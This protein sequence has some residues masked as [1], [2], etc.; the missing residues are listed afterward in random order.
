MLRSLKAIDSYFSIFV[1][2]VDCALEN[3][4]TFQFS[5]PPGSIT[6][7]LRASLRE[8]SAGDRGGLVVEDVR[9]AGKVFAGKIST[10]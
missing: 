6:D 9:V 2:F 4:H 10:T 8:T 7:L 5:L 3:T 1:P